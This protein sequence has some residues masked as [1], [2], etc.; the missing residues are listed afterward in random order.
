MT[1]SSP[2]DPDPDPDLCRRGVL[3]FGQ[4][5]RLWEKYRL[6]CKRQRPSAATGEVQVGATVCMRNAPFYHVGAVG[7]T[8]MGGAPRVGQLLQAAWNLTD[9]CRFKILLP[10]SEPRKPA[11]R[12]GQLKTKEAADRNDMPPPPSPASSTCSDASGSAASTGPVVKRARRSAPKNCSERKDEEEWSLADVIFIEESKNIPYG[13]VLK[14][15]GPYA[16][17]YFCQGRE[18]PATDDPLV[19]LNESRLCRKD[20]LMVIKPGS[21]PR[22]PE[23][24]Q[25]LPKKIALPNSLQVLTYA[26]DG[27]GLHCIVSSGGKLS[28]NVYSLVSSKPDSECVL[29]TEADIFCGRQPGAIALKTTGEADQVTLLLDGNSTVYPLNK[30]CTETSIR[31]PLTFDLMPLRCLALGSHY[32]P[33]VAPHQKTSVALAV[34]VVETQ[35]LMPKILRCDL[36]AVTQLLHS[37]TQDT[38]EC[39]GGGGGWL[40]RGN[41]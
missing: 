3:P 16:V 7:Y 29:P 36:D 37:L 27:K 20:E 10:P 19:M 22:V 25:K 35:I 24:F 5:K 12:E 13:K 9:V 8:T 14:I 21:P 2:C 28:Y 31:D 11:L 39:G 1:L 30:T 4:R 38:S 40:A 6:K 33:F 23:C 34:M 32:L 17:V 18:A 41:Y 15:D 26:V